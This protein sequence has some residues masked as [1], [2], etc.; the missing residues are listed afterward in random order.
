ML[1]KAKLK[2]IK[3]LQLKKYRKE[4]QRFIVEGARSVAELLDSDFQITMLAA[5]PA[6]IGQQAKSLAKKEMEILESSEQ[7]P[8]SFFDPPEEA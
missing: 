1:S 6:F 2:Y 7:Q 5:T 4:E 3:S 8:V